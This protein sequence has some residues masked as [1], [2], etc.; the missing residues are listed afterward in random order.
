RYGGTGLGL[1]ISRELARLLGGEIRLDSA[2]GHGSTFTLF[3]PQ[4]HVGARSQPPLAVPV[5]RVPQQPAVPFQESIAVTPTAEPKPAQPVQPAAPENLSIPDDR[6]HILPG[7][8]SVLII[9]DDH[10]FAQS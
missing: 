5:P 6:A 2:E 1:A 10:A 3:L 7:E 4:V 8:K 9:E